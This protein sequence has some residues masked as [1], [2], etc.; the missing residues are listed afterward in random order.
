MEG[1]LQ[2]HRMKSLVAKCMSWFRRHDRSFDLTRY[3]EARYA[4]GGTSGEGSYGRLAEFKA[5]IVN[6]FI[7]SHQIESAIEFGCG[8]GNQLSMLHVPSYVGLDISP[9]VVRRCIERFG[10]DETK[11]FFLFASR[12]FE[13]H[14]GIFAADLVL[15]LDVIFHLVGDD[16]FQAYMRCLCMSC[17]RYLIVYTTDFD[18]Q[19]QGHQ[20]HHAASKWMKGRNDFSLLRTITN[21]YPGSADDL[22]QSDAVFLIYER[23]SAS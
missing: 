13:D 9:T 19:A 10:A 18:G 3:W 20:H 4:A 7:E 1:A 6:E 11:S 21:P 12:C 16:E 22:N 2:L 23:I 14:A 8:D 17:R 5:S 15:S